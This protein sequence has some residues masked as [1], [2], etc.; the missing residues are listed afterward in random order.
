MIYNKP[1][2]EIYDIG[3]S[4]YRGPL[5][6]VFERFQLCLKEYPCSWFFRICADSPLLDIEIF[7]NMTAYIKRQ[8]VGLVTNVFPRTYP[9]GQSAEML[10]AATF[11]TIDPSRLTS[12]EEEHITRVYYNHQDEY[13]IVNID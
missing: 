2:N 5:N 11:A 7:Q 1:I 9:H 4:I 13:R 8:D 6:N 10:N 12:E 3:I